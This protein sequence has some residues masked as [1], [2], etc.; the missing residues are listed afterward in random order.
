[1]GRPK[2]EHS[3]S[4]K[5][6]IAAAIAGIDQEGAA[7]LGVSRVARR[8]GIKPPAIYKHLESGA[9]LQRATAITLWGQYLT[10]C[11]QTL[12]GRSITTNLLKQL[13]HFTRNFAKTYPGRYQVMM[14]VQLQP[15]DPDASVIIHKLLAF[16]RRAL[17]DYP[18][19]DT[20][21]IDVMRMVNAAIYGFIALEQG[22]LM[23]LERP[24]DKS[25]EVMLEGLIAAIATISERDG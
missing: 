25:Y 19:T 9:A 8:L 10:G 18:L 7:A 15:S 1:M 24:T 21:L 13:G 5:D 3:L 17:S 2:K 16:L 12:A 23:T 14:Q 6:V 11:Q 4:R 22:G 20:Q